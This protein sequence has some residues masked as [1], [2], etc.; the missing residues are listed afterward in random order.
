MF[1]DWD[2]WKVRLEVREGN[3]VCLGN[4]E[5][6]EFLNVT[7]QPLLLEA[8]PPPHLIRSFLLKALLLSFLRE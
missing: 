5:S 7:E 8:V 1:I 4:S 3:G 6:P 2:E